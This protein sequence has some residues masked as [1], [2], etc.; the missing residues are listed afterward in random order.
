MEEI[1]EDY[2]RKINE[3][4]DMIKSENY[5]GGDGINRKLDRLKCKRGCYRAFVVELE[6]LSK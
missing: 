5:H 3:L 2:K 4:N 6:R 1:I